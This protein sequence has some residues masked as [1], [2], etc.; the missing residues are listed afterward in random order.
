MTRVVVIG[1]GQAGVGVAEG[2]RAKDSAAQVTVIGG[3]VELP[4]ERPPLSK[5]V[6]LGKTTIDD[7]RLRSQQWYQ[8]H[9]VDLRLATWVER[10]DRDAR[11]VILG[12]GGVLPYDHLVLATGSRPRRLPVPG[13]DLDG[14]LS[15][16]TPDDSARLRERLARAQHVVII[17]AGFIGLEVA[18]AAT[19]AGHRPAVIELAD[20][21]LA[22]VAGPLLSAQVAARHL[23]R[24]VDL[25]LSTGVTELRGTDGR[26]TG[27]VTSTG[28]VLP[29]D[30]VL[31]GVGSV[32]VDDLASA[33]GL[34][35]HG[36]ILV[37][38]TLRTSDPAISA[39][40]DCCR[41]PLGDQ[42]M[43]LESV[44]NAVDQ[45]RH[46][47]ARLAATTPFWAPYRQV[48]WFWSTQGD[49]KLQMVGVP[50]QQDD[51]I[52]RGDLAGGRF[53]VF[54]YDG[55]RLT[56]VESVN[57]P[58]GHMIGRRLL[59]AGVSP[60]RTQAADAACDLKALAAAGQ[61]PARTHES[62]V[63]W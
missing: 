45:A 43:R 48:P 30:L 26:V 61:A 41:F 63:T 28:E 23:E 62:A 44:Q 36:G 8:A 9:N 25:R 39:I 54:R 10:I 32:P 24:G 4:Y 20:R 47:A 2:L 53:S 5:D 52:I 60:T 16:S 42:P 38:E 11:T 29:A 46:V 35:C 57:H 7:V 17:G 34:D 59:S 6:L 56:C 3:E 33:A 21:V 22:R 1:S 51:E 40:G 49:L 55:D 15:L 37:D 50:E 27:V 19:A 18:A 12:D 14:V 58:S 13:A 31:V